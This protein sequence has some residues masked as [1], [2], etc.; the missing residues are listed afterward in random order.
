MRMWHGKLDVQR[1][2]NPHMHAYT[3]RSCFTALCFMPFCFNTP[4]QFTPIVTLHSLTFGLMSFG[5][6]VC[7]YLNLLFLGEYNL[8]FTLSFSGRQLVGKIRTWWVQK[9]RNKRHIN[10]SLQ[11]KFCKFQI[12]PGYVE[13]YMTTSLGTMIMLQTVTPV[14]PLLQKLVHRL[15]CPPL[16]SVFANFILYGESIMVS[17][18]YNFQ[19]TVCVWINWIQ[20]STDSLTI[21]QHYMN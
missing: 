1:M 8:F 18:L 6:F 9:Y 17:I 3:P 14:E 16:L 20:K 19:S 4:C 13:M 12:G 21:Q 11:V 7:I 15:Y 2:K 10:R 5:W